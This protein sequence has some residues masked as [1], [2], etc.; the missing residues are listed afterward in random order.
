MKI[1]YEFA[2]GDVMEIEVEDEIGMFILQSRRQESSEGRKHRRWNRSLD[3][4]ND[5]SSWIRS[6]EHN[7][8]DLLDRA[9]QE[10][11]RMRKSEEIRETVDQLKGR[12]KELAYAMKNKKFTQEKYAEKKGVT[13]QAISSQ[14]QTIRKKFK[15][16]L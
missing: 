7:P 13:Q 10:E 14:V 6:D 8:D 5:K 15:K 2:N 9:S 1:R 12:Q 16:F 3:A 4:A 11:D